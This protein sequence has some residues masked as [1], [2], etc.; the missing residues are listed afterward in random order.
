MLYDLC[1]IPDTIHDEAAKLTEY[2]PRAVGS[3][4]DIQIGHRMHHSRIMSYSVYRVGCI[5]HRVACI[6]SH[7]ACIVHHVMRNASYRAMRGITSTA[8]HDC[9]TAPLHVTCV[10]GHETTYVESVVARMTCSKYINESMLS[11]EIVEK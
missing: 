1:S 2:E 7:V 3:C 8:P 11:V 9:A 5:V 10:V 4:V 6:V